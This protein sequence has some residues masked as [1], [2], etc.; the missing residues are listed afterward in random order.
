M[1]ARNRLPRPSPL[2]A[3]ATKPAMSTNSTVAAT[4]LR[5]LLMTARA[6]RRWS[7]TW[8]T[9]TFVSVVEK[10][11]A[12]TRAEPP[13]SALNR[14]DLPALGRPTRPSRSIGQTLLPAGSV[15]DRVKAHGEEEEQGQAEQ[16]Q[17]RAQAQRASRLTP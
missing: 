12:A 6:E 7:E 17:P 13:V 11:W 5:L 10:G 14:L 1:P 3:P 4:T 16:G 8:A 15:Q 2:E 9:P